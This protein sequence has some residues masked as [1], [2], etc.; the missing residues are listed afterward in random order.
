MSRKETESP[1]GTFLI[2]PNIRHARNGSVGSLSKPSQMDKETH[3]QA[4]DLIHNDASQSETLTTFN[5]Y[6]SPPT[7]SSLDGKSI[8]SE[9]QGGLS[10]LYNRLRASVGG[11]SQKVEGSE[12]NEDERGEGDL[13]T[14]IPRLLASNY[15]PTAKQVSVSL[16]SHS[17]S[18]SSMIL[19]VEAPASRLQSPSS[20]TVREAQTHDPDGLDK[21]PKSSSA[22]QSG[23]PKSSISSASLLKSTSSSL[24]QIPQPSAISPAL[25]EVSV[26][27]VK[28]SDRS[29]TAFSDSQA[30]NGSINPMSMKVDQ[31]T[32][33]PTTPEVSMD[34]IQIIHN[35]ADNHID[36]TNISQDTQPPHRTLPPVA[37]NAARVHFA[38]RPHEE[39]DDLA[40]AQLAKVISPLPVSEQMN[41]YTSRKSPVQ[42]KIPQPYRPE[43]NLS[44][45]SSSEDVSQSV[46]G[47]DTPSSK[48]HKEYEIGDSYFTQPSSH[49]R[50]A[51]LVRVDAD[52]R[53]LNVAMSQIKSRVLSKEYW[54]RD[55]N[56]K[57][58]FYCGDSFSTFRRKHHCRELLSHQIYSIVLRVY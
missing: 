31:E 41:P 14:K 6:T 27:A 19:D 24:K 9:L 5:E 7:S 16:R 38:R 34:Q 11:I 54:M 58:C 53:A 43:L 30:N 28:D 26:S 21:A 29:S 4:L 47:T 23:V 3:S 10:G 44:R 48:L 35:V 56:A 50:I 20:V 1:A 49:S 22:Q 51:E 36:I 13:S 45:A 25:A 37:D 55:E 18:V 15:T 42:S 17:P 32:S 33:W 52:P 8:T 39:K 46:R 57:D 40:S 2:L 12:L